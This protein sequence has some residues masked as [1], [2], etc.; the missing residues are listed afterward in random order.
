M[1]RISNLADGRVTILVDPAY[2]AGRQANLRVAFIRDISVA[3]LPAE[4]TIWP[5]R[6]G[7]SSRL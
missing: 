2:L 6:P 5:P 1:L 7:V 4:R 3:A